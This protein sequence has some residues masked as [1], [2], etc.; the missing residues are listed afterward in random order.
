LHPRT[1]GGQ[2]QMSLTQY[3][4]NT[5]LIPAGPQ[6][7]PTTGAIE[8]AT[9]AGRSCAVCTCGLPGGSGGT[10]AGEDESGGGGT[11]IPGS[12]GEDGVAG[13]EMNEDHETVP[14]A[15]PVEHIGSELGMDGP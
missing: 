13:G 11:A 3:C 12:A 14:N 5:E 2:A 7:N 8:H 6:C 15:M 4:S 1:I 10:G 9:V